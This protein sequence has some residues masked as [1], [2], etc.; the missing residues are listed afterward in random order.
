MAM[1]RLN[2]LSAQIF[3]THNGHILCTIKFQN[4]KGQH[5]D[6]DRLHNLRKTILDGLKN[7][8]PLRS[9][10]KVSSSLF[11]V[12]TTISYL[13]NHGSKQTCIEISTLDS[14]GLLAKIG[15]TLGNCGCLISAARIATTGERADDFFAIT[16]VNG[17]P[18]DAKQQEL[19]S[20]ALYEVLEGGT[21]E[22]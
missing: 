17:L 4:Q 5:V 15:I 7:S 6:N 11:N 13:K 20:K 19:L 10:P 14:P 1:K 12:P 16:D 21:T 8:T 2:V 3:L 9:L 18:L 22:N